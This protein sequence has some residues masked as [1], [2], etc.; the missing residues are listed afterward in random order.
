MNERNWSEYFDVQDFT[1]NHTVNRK[2]EAEVFLIKQH[3]LA[4]DNF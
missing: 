3:L 1:V 4:S 2:A